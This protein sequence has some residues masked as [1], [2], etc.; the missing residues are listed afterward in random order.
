MNSG[1]RLSQSTPLT[2]KRYVQSQ[3]M[4]QGPKRAELPENTLR[5]GSRGCTP[6]SKSMFDG[7]GLDIFDGNNKQVWMDLRSGW[8][9]LCQE[10]IGGSMGVHIGD[11]DHTTLQYFL[12]IYAAYPREWSCGTLLEHAKHAYPA[13]AGYASHSDSNDHLHVVS[14]ALRRAELEALLVHLCEPPHQALSHV[15]QGNSPSSF[16]YSGERMWKYHMT[17]LVIQ[18]FPAMGAGVQTNFTQKCWS[19]TNLDRMYDALNVQRIKRRYGWE[20]YEAREKKAFFMRSLLWEMLGA[21]CRPELDELTRSLV[22]LAIRRMCFELVFLESMRYMNR[23]QHVH[24]L[25]DRPTL[26]ELQA[27]NLT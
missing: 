8:C 7:K 22:D 17:R 23:V 3:V 13:L 19:R 18:L 9:H 1:G 14:D 20:P 16:W 12:Y 5:L 24:G 27:F 2:L 25:M 26:A 15:L 6:L 10:P 4:S 11:R 21:E